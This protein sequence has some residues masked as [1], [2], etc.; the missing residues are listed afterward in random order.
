MFKTWKAKNF[1]FLRKSHDISKKAVFLATSDIIW[2]GGLSAGKNMFRTPWNEAC[3]RFVVFWSSSDAKIGLLTSMMQ[4][5]LYLCP[6]WFLPLG[7][8]TEHIPLSC[9]KLT[10][11]GE[12]TFRLYSFSSE[13][14][15]LLVVFLYNSHALAIF[16]L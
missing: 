6:M 10:D 13:C 2:G 8:R 9:R 14:I 1:F 3:F 16:L 4:K 11:H 5:K 15:L 7:L 12:K